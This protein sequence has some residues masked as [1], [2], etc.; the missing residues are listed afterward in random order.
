MFSKLLQSTVES[1]EIEAWLQIESKGIPMQRIGM[2]LRLKAGSAEAYK[3]YHREVWPEVLAKLQ[4]CNIRNYSIYFKDD[5]LFSYFEYHGNDLEA[6]RLQMASH[7]KTRE[8]WV[9]M[10]TLQ[11]PLPTRKE[12]EWWAEME[13]VFHLD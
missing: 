4:E 3:A 13:E 5:L 11:D 2:A 1:S 7:A 8:W 12:G 10:E 6:D 9:I